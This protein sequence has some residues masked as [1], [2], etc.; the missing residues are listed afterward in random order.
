MPRQLIDTADKARALVGQ[1][2]RLE[3]Y[4]MYEEQIGVVESYSDTALL[5]ELGLA[6]GFGTRVSA[7]YPNNPLYAT[8][9]LPGQPLQADPDPIPRPQSFYWLDAQSDMDFEEYVDELIG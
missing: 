1:L 6:N 9:Y 2:V 5:L 4:N 3:W 8:V 7:P